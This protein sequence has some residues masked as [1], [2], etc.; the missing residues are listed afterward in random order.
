MHQLIE[1]LEGENVLADDFVVYGK[2]HTDD[3]ARAKKLGFTPKSRV[4][5]GQ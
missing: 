5:M 1:G 4:E 3:E 2:N